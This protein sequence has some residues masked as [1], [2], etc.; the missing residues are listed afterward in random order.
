MLQ[1]VWLS[2]AAHCQAASHLWGLGASVVILRSL[3]A[4]VDRDGYAP[5]GVDIFDELGVPRLL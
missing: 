1:K 2:P 3:F 4:P 5:S